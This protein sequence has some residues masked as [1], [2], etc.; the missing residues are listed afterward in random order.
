MIDN[1][2]VKVEVVNPKFGMHGVSVHGVSG[3]LGVIKKSYHTN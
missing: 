1:R 2:V 3:C